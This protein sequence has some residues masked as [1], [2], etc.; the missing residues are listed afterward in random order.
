[1]YLAGVTRDE[2]NRSLALPSQS[3][4]VP[5]TVSWILN[6]LFLPFLARVRDA[7]ATD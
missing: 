4:A 6:D 1:V 3:P 5:V 2:L 7:L